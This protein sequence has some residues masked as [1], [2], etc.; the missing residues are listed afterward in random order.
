MERELVNKTASQVE[1]IRLENEKYNYKILWGNPLTG[2]RDGGIF[3]N[4]VKINGYA[5]ATSG[6]EM[7]EYGKEIEIRQY[8]RGGSCNIV[9][10]D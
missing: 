7:G 9:L 4:S 1:I 2:D 10:P 8:E 5:F 3:A 6:M